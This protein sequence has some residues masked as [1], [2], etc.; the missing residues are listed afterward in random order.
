V[1]L[2]RD[3]AHDSRMRQ[4]IEWQAIERSAEKRS[5]GG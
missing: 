5:S 2:L 1:S 3:D 4:R